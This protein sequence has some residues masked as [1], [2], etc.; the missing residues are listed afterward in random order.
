MTNEKK[1]Y[2]QQLD[3]LIQDAL[4]RIFEL[5]N[6]NGVESKH[7][8]SQ[9]LKIEAD[10]FMF[11][12]EGGRYLTEIT[13]GDLVDNNGYEYSFYVL[14]TEDLLSLVDHLIEKHS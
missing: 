5:I 10:E 4:I 1:N 13:N 11:N 14:D 8:S 7:N 12:L 3:D 9:C 2:V 6:E